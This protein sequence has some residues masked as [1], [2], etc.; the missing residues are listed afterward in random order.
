VATTAQVKIPPAKVQRQSDALERPKVRRLQQFEGRDRWIVLAMVGIPTLLHVALVWIP[1]ISSILL[2]FTDWKGLRLDDI[3]WVGLK[4]YEQIFTAFQKNFFQALI[5]NAVLLVFLFIGPT[6]LGILLAYLLDRDIR[7]TRFYQ[8]VFFTPVVLSLAVV[9]FMWKSVIYSTDNGLATQLFGGGHSVDWLGNQSFVIPFGNSYGLS[10]NFLAILV[11]MAWRHTGY[12]MVL[13]L[14]GL[15][16]V[17]SSLREAAMLDGSN[18]WQTFRHVIFPSLKPINVVI[19]VI[20]VIE[21]LRAFDIIFVLNVPRKTEVLS[22]LTTNNLLGEG[23][24]NVGRGSAYA[25]ILFILCVGFV[26]WYVTNHFRN[27]QEGADA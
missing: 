25:T 12:I 16:S 18:E 9:G 5:N 22:I 19:A 10:W 14:A 13:Y 2:S 6:T 7:G 23:G 1:T 26:V 15:K 27:T 21:A 20:T 4:N 3:N 24:G 11:A 8:G 17:D